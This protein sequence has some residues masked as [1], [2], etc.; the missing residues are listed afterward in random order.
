MVK[1]ASQSDTGVWPVS[2]S[3]NDGTSDSFQRV[4]PFEQFKT[5]S[6]RLV[7]YDVIPGVTLSPKIFLIKTYVCTYSCLMY[8]Y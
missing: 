3:T 7:N 2:I 8:F 1:E 6:A 5:D 4:G